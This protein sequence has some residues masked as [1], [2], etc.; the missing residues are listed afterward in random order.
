ML[1]T[2]NRSLRSFKATEGIEIQYFRLRQQLGILVHKGQRQGERASAMVDFDDA[3][4]ADAWRATVPSKVR[5]RPER[6]SN[7]LG[8]GR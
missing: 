8:E 6:R 4:G 3:R 7:G 1:E 2:F 5:L